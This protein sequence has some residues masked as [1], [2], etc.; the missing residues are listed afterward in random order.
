LSYELM[1]VESF[2][3]NLLIHTEIPIESKIS[4]GSRFTRFSWRSRISRRSE[5]AE[6]GHTLKRNFAREFPRGR[7]GQPEADHSFPEFFVQV[8]NCL[9]Q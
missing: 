1:M 8:V 6:I 3:A 4:L 2:S 9:R 7:C 5:L